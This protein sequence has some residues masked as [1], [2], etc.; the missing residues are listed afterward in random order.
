MTLDLT[1]TTQPELDAAAGLE[2]L[3]PKPWI[4]ERSAAASPACVDLTRCQG[5]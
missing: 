5:L 1:T 4:I 3:G 2:G